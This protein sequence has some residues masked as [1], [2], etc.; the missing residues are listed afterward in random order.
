MIRQERKE[1]R[2]ERETESDGIKR[3]RVYR[4]RGKTECVRNRKEPGGKGGE[5]GGE[6]GRPG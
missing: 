1:T 3:P 6:G 2:T 5:G 4:E